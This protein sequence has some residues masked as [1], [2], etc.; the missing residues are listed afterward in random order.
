MIFHV[1]P[2]F[3]LRDQDDAESM[4]MRDYEFDFDLNLLGIE[5]KAM[6]RDLWRQK[7]LGEVDGSFQTKV[8][9]HGV[10]FVKITPIK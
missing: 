2:Y 6:V 8:P 10:T 7:D 1:D 9:Y 5:G 3:N 4:Q